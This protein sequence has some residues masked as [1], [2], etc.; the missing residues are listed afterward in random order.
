DHKF[1]PAIVKVPVGVKV[2]LIV[3]NQDETVEEFESF[4]LN[5]EKIVRGG[6][7]IKVFLPP[8]KAGE[9]EFI[10]EFNQETAKGKV[11]AE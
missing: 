10:G 11:V 9:Y 6:K 1:E 7:S 3:D 8:L 2:L 4:S 5:R